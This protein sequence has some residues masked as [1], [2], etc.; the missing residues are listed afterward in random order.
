MAKYH[1]TATWGVFSC[2]L[3][4]YAHMAAR[5]ASFF[6]FN[7][8]IL[9]NRWWMP[10]P[11]SHVYLPRISSDWKQVCLLWRKLH[12]VWK[13]DSVMLIKGLV[14]SGA[15][16]PGSC[17]IL[18]SCPLNEDTFAC[19]YPNGRLRVVCSLSRIRVL[20][21]DNDPL[22]AVSSV[23]VSKGHCCKEQD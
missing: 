18:F 15:L 4:V 17:I 19:L 2:I 20:N 16:D 23:N 11:N 13:G 3:N 1:L 6:G 8:K 22:A 21:Q 12:L 5:L 7:Q 14:F 10:P 9:P